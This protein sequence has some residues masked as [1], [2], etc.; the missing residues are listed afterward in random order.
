MKNRQE[1]LQQARRILLA[2]GEAIVLLDEISWLASKDKDFAGKLKKEKIEQGL[3]RDAH[4]ENLVSWD[5]VMGY[6]FDNLILN[7]LDE[8]IRR[9][10]VPPESIVSAAPCFQRKTRRHDA[11]QIDLLIQT[12]N[13]LYVCEIKLRNRID[14][15]VMDEVRRKIEKRPGRSKYSVRPVLFYEGELAPAVNRSDFFCR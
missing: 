4:L 15:G 14:A 10:D 11:C 13:T 12:R 1:Q 5:A 6:Q 7:N 8:V 3:F 9:L 2:E